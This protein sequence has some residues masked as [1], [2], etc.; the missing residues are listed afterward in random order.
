MP[1]AT[2][3]KNAIRPSERRQLIALVKMKVRTLRAEV[4]ERHA[5]QLAEID[6]RVAKKFKDD[7]ARATELRSRLSALTDEVNERAIRLFGEYADVVEPRGSV[8]TLPYFHRR[9]D[10]KDKLRAA[11][12]TAVEAGT[13]AARLELAKLEAQLLEELMTDGLKSAAAIAFVKKMPTAD[14]L[15]PEKRLTEIESRF[16]GGE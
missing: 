5:S 12:R 2:D 6:G 15:L 8:Y 13:K 11:L 9:D 16:K 14:A 7:D 4:E 10:G 1:T 3:E